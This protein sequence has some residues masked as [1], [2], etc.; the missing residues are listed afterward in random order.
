MSVRAA[1]ASGILE[2]AAFLVLASSSEILGHGFK[3]RL[4]CGVN[5]CAKY[6]L[7]SRQ[8]RKLFGWLESVVGA[9]AS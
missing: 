4:Y 8:Y 9:M 3:P 5:Y 1:E 2:V 7:S 6:I